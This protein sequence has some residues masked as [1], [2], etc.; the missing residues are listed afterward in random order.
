MTLKCFSLFFFCDNRHC[1]LRYQSK[2]QRVVYTL[3]NSR[4][5]FTSNIISMFWMCCSV[6]CSR[7]EFVILVN[8]SFFSFQFMIWDLGDMG[9]M[10]NQ[11]MLKEE[12]M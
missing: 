5:I 12:C 1:K 11:L 8:S 7:D 6:H 4:F 10:A 3:P 9:H 2:S